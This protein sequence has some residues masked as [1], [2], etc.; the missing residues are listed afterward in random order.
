L[1][2]G[3]PAVLLVS[4]V[5]LVA[6][7]VMP[8]GAVMRTVVS[9]SLVVTI[10]LLVSALDT[11]AQPT[12][13]VYRLGVLSGSSAGSPPVEAFRQG[14]RELGYVEG[15]NIVV[16]Y[17]FAEGR[18]DRL[19]AL[20]A[21]LVHLQVDVIAAGPT[22]PAVAAESATG[23]I[24]VVMLGAATP[25]ELGLVASLARP[26]GNLTGSSWSVDAAIIGKGLELLM[27]A[28]PTVRV[29]AILSNP[30]NP[31]HASALDN[32]KV[33]ARSLGLR[34]Q[35]WEAR[36]PD[37]FDGA[38]R[39]MVKERVSAVLV[40]ADALFVTHRGT[41]ADLQTKYRL[42]SMPT[43][44]ANVEAGGLM[45]YGPDIVAVWRRTALVVDKGAKPADLPVEQ[46][47]T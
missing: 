7:L 20:A 41:L 24:P 37:E 32:I 44:R 14:L 27:Q 43:L 22:P 45:S 35:F 17:R 23:T 39:A 28:V 10:S 9:L 25:V 16:E 31:A 3:P 40:V 26:G 12:N 46:P 11:H 42:P 15:R 19:P 1:S 30:T 36:A 8:I 21:E 34:L 5:A 13:K 18:A 4:L 38:F 6:P 2:D 47:T 29:V 33:A